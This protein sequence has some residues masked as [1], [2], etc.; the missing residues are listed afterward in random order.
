M[1][2]AI[3]VEVFLPKRD[4][5][6]ITVERVLNYL[7]S[8]NHEVLILAPGASVATCAGYE[9]VCAGGFPLLFYPGLRYNTFD[10]PMARKLLD[11]KPDLI[12]LFDPIMLGLQTY[13]FARFFMPRT[14]LIYTYCTNIVM[15]TSIFGFPQLANIFWAMLKIQHRNSSL[16][17]VPSASIKHEL[18]Y[19]DFKGAITVW[20]RPVDSRRFHPSKRRE[21]LRVKWSGCD[22]SRPVYPENKIILLFVSRISWEKGLNT[23]RLAYE[24]L[25]KSRFHL[26]IVGDGPARAEFEPDFLPGD[27]TFVGWRQGEDLAEAYASADMFI[28][29]SLTETFGNVLLEAASSGLPIVACD[30]LG[31]RDLVV[32]GKTGLL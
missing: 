11:F 27:V 31:V 32:H 22:F 26:V 12:Q 23:L 6:T 19:H 20:P 8:Q 15:Y 21:D 14:P 4:G 5:V 29:A 18:T 24:G 10:I 30:A 1:R 7:R 2:I 9:V 25:D 28:F 16:T 13:Y 17:L 3:V